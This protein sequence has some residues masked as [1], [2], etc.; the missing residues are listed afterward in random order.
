MGYK[1][2]DNSDSEGLIEACGTGWDKFKKRDEAYD[3]W[4]IIYGNG[5]KDFL[6]YVLTDPTKP[7]KIQFGSLEFNHEPFYVGYGDAIR[8]LKETVGV[9]RQKDKYTAKTVRLL[10]IRSMGHNARQLTIGKYFTKEKA[11][12]VERKLMNIINKSFLTNSMFHYCEVPLLKGDCN[13]MDECEYIADDLPKDVGI[14][15]I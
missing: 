4:D 2:N 10:E 1:N 9:G 6:V 5:I 11:M 7:I 12:L 14:L 15:R 13:V 8:R 3:Q